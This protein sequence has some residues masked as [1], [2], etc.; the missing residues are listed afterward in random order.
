LIIA[1]QCSRPQTSGGQA[2]RNNVSGAALIAGVR[3]KH[4][5]F[6]DA[7]IADAKVS[8]SYRGERSEFRS[9]AD[10]VA[11]SLRLMWVSDAFLAQACYRAKARLQSLGVP[12]LPR[13]AHRMAM[14]TAQVCIGDP[15]V[16]DA[17]VYLAH[18]QVVIDGFVEVHRGVVIFPWVTVGLR[19]GD[20]RGP[21]IGPDVHIGTGA[22]IIGPVTVGPRARIGANSVVVDDVAE[23]ITVVGSPA[24]PANVR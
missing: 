6:V 22:K 7:L 5:R 12:V 17:G 4:P 14:M 15:V 24:R 16:V 8:A 1:D 9:R 13:L 23:G 2:M 19:A 21:T 18:G 20:V 3:A 10:A 11:Q